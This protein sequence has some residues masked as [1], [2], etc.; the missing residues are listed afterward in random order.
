V[1]GDLT[2][3]QKEWFSRA[4]VTAVSAA[5]GYTVEFRL[6]DV[7]GVDATIYDGGVSVD[8]QLK[9]TS[10][11]TK[12]DEFVSHDLDVRTYDLLRGVRSSPGYLAV[13]VLPKQ[14]SRWLHHTR[15]RL[16]LRHC[17]YWLDLSGLP[18]TTNTS[19]VRIHLPLE[20]TLS[21]PHLREI[22]RDARRRL[23][24]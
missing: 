17:G 3:Q 7:D 6:N 22:M 16:L 18:S 20:N 19:T 11:P 4:F 23:T 10:S 9:A 5:A 13:V 14:L 24:A 8:L 21:V 12:T 2:Q 15:E 1:V